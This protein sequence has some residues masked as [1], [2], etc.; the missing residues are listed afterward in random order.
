MRKLAIAALVVMLLL[1]PSGR[2]GNAVLQDDSEVVLQSMDQ[3]FVT[4]V[5]TDKLR[6]VV[7]SRTG[8]TYLVWTQGSGTY[9]VGGI[10]VLVNPDGTPVIAEEVTR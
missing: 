5:K 2:D 10:T 1:W 7:D 3:R 4:D 6:T 8:V 9:R